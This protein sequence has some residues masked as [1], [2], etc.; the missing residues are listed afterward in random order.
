MDKTVVCINCNPNK[1]KINPVSLK[2]DKIK[3]NNS[4]FF[5]KLM[6]VELKQKIGL[7]NEESEINGQEENILWMLLS[8]YYL[9][10][11][12]E[13]S[14]GQ[15][16]NIIQDEVKI[17]ENITHLQLNSEDEGKEI[18]EKIWLLLKDIISDCKTK[19]DFDEKFNRFLDILGVED[20]E[21]AA[22]KEKFNEYVHKESL[23][24]LEKMSREKSERDGPVEI[25]PGYHDKL[26]FTDSSDKNN[27][28]KILKEIFPGSSN[29]RKIF[30]EDLRIE[31][32]TVLPVL[33]K[34]DIGILTTSLEPV[35]KDE[36]LVRGE[37]DK[38][39]S[40]FFE[41]LIEKI[42]VIAKDKS[43][44]L[45]IRLKPDHLGEMIIK[46]INE[47]K[48]L[49]AQIFVENP[50]VRKDLEAG[51]NNLKSQIVKRGF[52]DVNIELVNIKNEMGFYNDF[53]GRGR[54]WF[55]K[56]TKHKN[57]F[58]IEDTKEPFDVTG[59]TK[60]SKN[61]YFWS[62]SQSNIDYFV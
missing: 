3:S 58:K 8:S 32:S 1:Q 39:D 7:I 55:Y 59:I 6:E 19:K 52:E 47:E 17:P 15:D 23:G 50:F 53:S 27:V 57:N 22:I 54:D 43:K 4:K 12:P 14:K 49:K 37:K 10:F 20:V 42:S 21:K 25:T 51:L 30:S 33:S 26:E 48:N 9:N 29:Y 13:A 28:I 41:E 18:E 44:E 24:F 35:N 36:I 16:I 60:G 2:I 38:I 46:V 5:N 56:A 45:H 11:F 40:N 34:E 61:L 62:L 31:E